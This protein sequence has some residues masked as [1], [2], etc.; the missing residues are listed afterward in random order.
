M[1]NSVFHQM[2]MLL[3]RTYTQSPYPC[4]VPRTQYPGLGTPTQSPIPSQFPSQSLDH[5]HTQSPGLSIQGS[6]SRAQYPDPAPSTQYSE[7]S[8]STQ[9]PGLSTPTQYPG[10][11]TRG[12]NRE[13]L[14]YISYL[15][16]MA[17]FGSS[18]TAYTHAPFWIGLQVYWGH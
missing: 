5:T 6:V 13:S 16:E 4:T 14:S 9:W 7:L 1:Y 18:L 11:G 3:C 12:S 17:V 15:D 8:T 10:G 2:G